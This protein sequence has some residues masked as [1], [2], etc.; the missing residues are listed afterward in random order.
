[1]VF[2]GVYVYFY[3]NISDEYFEDY[4][5]LSNII[6]EDVS[7]IIGRAYSFRIIKYYKHSMD[8]YYLSCDSQV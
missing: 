8:E 7:N 2:S 5:Y 1:M 6:F 4:I 3:K